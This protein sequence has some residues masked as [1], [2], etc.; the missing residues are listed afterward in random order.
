MSLAE[1][2]GTQHDFSIAQE[3]ARATLIF[4]FGL[5]LMRLS[6]RRIF[7]KWSALDVIV[8]VVV[9]SNL[10][11]ALTGGSPLWGTLAASAIFVA[12]H[13]LLAH[14]IAGFPRLARIVEGAPTSIGKKGSV[15]ETALLR[16]GLS[17]EDIAVALR[18]KGLTSLSQTRLLVIEPNGK[19]S[20]FPCD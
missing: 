4:F 9:G 15:D 11:R 7:A 18:Q 16:H 13:W 1:V 14:L 3:C 12:L 17:R 19:L 20:V 5:A 6:G 8:S 2:F 10:S